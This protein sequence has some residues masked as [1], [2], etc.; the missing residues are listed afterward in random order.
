MELPR[1]VLIAG[2]LIAGAIFFNGLK[3]AYETYVLIRAI[4][5]CLERA[6]DRYCY[7]RA[8]FEL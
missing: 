2:A 5:V 6:E 3:Q 8:A 7:P 1:A 4:D